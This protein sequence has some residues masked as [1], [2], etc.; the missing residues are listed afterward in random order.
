MWKVNILY[1]SPFANKN[2]VHDLPKPMRKSCNVNLSR[3]W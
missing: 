1:K 2:Y 3:Q